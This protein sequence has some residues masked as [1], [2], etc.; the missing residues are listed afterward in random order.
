MTTSE[1]DILRLYA[2]RVR[3]RFP[4]AQVWLYGSRARGDSEPDSDYDMCVVLDRVGGDAWKIL[5][6]IDWEI[7][8]DNGILITSVEFEREEFERGLSS[9]TPLVRNIR[10]EGIAA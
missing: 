3:E 5:S 1:R 8:L 9:Y 10:R 6:D 4:G 2:A 7:G